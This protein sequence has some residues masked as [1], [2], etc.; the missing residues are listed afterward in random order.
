MN[1]AEREPL[2]QFDYGYGYRGQNSPQQHM[3][4]RVDGGAIGI[5]LGLLAIGGVIVGAITIPMLA[6]KSAKAAAL[7]LVQPV[8]VRAASAQDMSYLAERETKLMREQFGMLQVELEKKGIHL[9]P[10][11]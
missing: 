4:L 9:P 11:H 8:A 6:D 7:E 2:E 5:A 3:N 10:V 1:T